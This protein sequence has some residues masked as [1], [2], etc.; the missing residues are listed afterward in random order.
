MR[1]SFL[2]KVQKKIAGTCNKK[3]AIGLALLLALLIY[4]IPIPYIDGYAKITLSILA[5]AAVFWVTEAIPLHATAFLIVI[6]TVI[7]GIHTPAVALAPFFSPVIAL[8]LGGFIISIAMEKYGL[9]KRVSNYIL[10]HVGT[11]PKFVLLGM[12]FIT[13]FL[14]FWMSNTATTAIM[15]VSVLPIISKIPKHDNFKKALVL[16]IPFAAN[17][18]GIGTPVGTPP[19]PIAISYLAETG[20]HISFLDWMIFTIPLTFIFLLL[21]WGVLIAMYPSETKCFKSIK[22]EIE[23]EEVEEKK[24]GFSKSQLIVLAVFIFTVLLWLTET[25]HGVHISIIAL[26]PVVFFLSTGLLSHDDFNKTPW[27]VLFLIGGGLTLSNAIQASGLGL[28]I[29]EQISVANLTIPIVISLFAGI[30]IIMT[31][32]MSN[33]ATAALLIPIVGAIGAQIQA[34]SFLVLA[35]AVGTSVAMAL[36]VSTAPNA[37]AYG[38]GKI[39]IKDMI[40]SGAIIS[41]LSLII[42]ST[43]GYLW[44]SFLG[45]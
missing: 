35:I 38:T 22:A 6:L 10:T 17:A 5:L 30:G 21:I 7:A 3:I 28:I 27:E 24:K 9:G 31:T 29:V 25:V 20:M 13:A 34:S 26:I 8:L 14:S 39:K 45:I 36:P 42:I 1:E 43:V 12:I 11:K 2:N 40:K 4:I 15:L 32:F 44:W 18:G 33:T 19:N 16:S 37:I 41:I 23:A